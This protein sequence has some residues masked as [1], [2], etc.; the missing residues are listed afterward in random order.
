MTAR[1]ANSAGDC[2]HKFILL[3]LDVICSHMDYNP[4]QLQ[5]VFFNLWD[6]VNNLQ[7]SSTR[8]AVSFVHLHAEFQH[9]GDTYNKNC[10]AGWSVN[11]GGIDC[12]ITDQPDCGWIARPCRRL[13]RIWGCGVSWWNQGDSQWWC[14]F[15]LEALSSWI[16]GITGGKSCLSRMSWERMT[17]L[18]H[19]RAELQSND[20][21]QVF[22]AQ[23][24]QSFI[25]IW[26]F[27]GWHWD[28]LHSLVRR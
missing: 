17:E 23:L 26:W 8:K 12:S 13:W 21:G 25:P 3:I 5:I 20:Q 27:I 19:R 2:N 15:P 9:D 18:E 7:N 11:Q 14:R 6:F 22:L 10:G 24:L 28:S 1:S 16:P 4:L